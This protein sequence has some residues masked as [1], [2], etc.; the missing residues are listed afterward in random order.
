MSGVVY[1]VPPMYRE[2]IRNV[3]RKIRGICKELSGNDDAPFFPIVEFLDVILPKHFEDF[4]LEIIDAEQMGDA[5]GITFPDDHLMQIRSDIYKRACQKQGRDRLTMAHELGHYVLHAN[6]GMAR[7]APMGS[8]K[9]WI[10]SEWQASCL[11]GELLVSVDHISK[12]KNPTE[13]SEMFGVTMTAAEYQW[14]VFKKEGIV[15]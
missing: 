15:R 2:P 3:A 7:M 10:S 12:C 11:A 4:S 6:L 8:I 14:N 5:H 1:Q 9:P 13:V